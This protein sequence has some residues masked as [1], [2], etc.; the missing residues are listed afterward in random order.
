MDK[1]YISGRQA[2]WLMV[3]TVI[4]TGILFLPGLAAAQAGKDAWIAPVLSTFTG[5]F[6]VY[7]SYK[8]AARFPR[9][10]IIEYLPSVVGK[11]LGKIIGFLYLLFFIYLTGLVLR[12]SVV[13]VV[14]AVLNRTPQVI[15]T[16]M[17]MLVA[18]IAA[19]L[20]IEVISRVNDWAFL[21][22]TLSV[23][24]IILL[25]L[26]DGDINNITPIFDNGIVPI[27][28]GTITS[29]SFRGEIAL[30]LLMLAPTINK[31]KETGKRSIQAVIIVGIILMLTTLANVFV[32]DHTEVARFNFP[33]F[34]LAKI[35]SIANFLERLDPIVLVVWI[36]GTVVKIAI[37]H[38]ASTL[39]FAQIFNLKN[40]RPLVLPLGVIITLL[41][42]IDFES[43]IQLRNFI[44]T[45]WPFLGLTFE[46]AIPI[47]ILLIAIIRKKGKKIKE[48]TND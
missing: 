42:I 20:G 17:I 5:I 1:E 41:S 22:M 24:I 4:G 48:G 11:V 3:T 10:S 6:I 19:R 21:I 26:K 18:V 39:S 16:V 36:T 12:E 38:Y 44:A 9:N 25:V 35:I 27:L 34:E 43:I 15:I 40:Y 7:I 8:L 32:F 31:P 13:F 2:M 46:V 47:F 29:T 37:L 33:T 23:T 14:A 28:K 30:F 45:T